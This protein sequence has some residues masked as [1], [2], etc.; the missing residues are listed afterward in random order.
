MKDIIS[1]VLQFVKDLNWKQIISTA[2]LVAAIA[3][4]SVYFTS[5]SVAQGS[6][7]GDRVVDKNVRDSTHYS[8][9]LEK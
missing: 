6:V 2:I 5:C 3:M 9:T 7:S 8:V 1:V 4:A